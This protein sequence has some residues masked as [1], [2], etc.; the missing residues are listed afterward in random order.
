MAARAAAVTPPRGE[1]EE[2]EVS[3]MGGGTE[4]KAVQRRFTTHVFRKTPT[5]GHGHAL[6]WG[7][8]DKQVRTAPP[9]CARG[10]GGGGGGRRVDARARR[11]RV[12]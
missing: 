4:K 11:V 7:F 3:E 6:C 1:E 5:A 2:D 8:M 12:D 9:R 10:G